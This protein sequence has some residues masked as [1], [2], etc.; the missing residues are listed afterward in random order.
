MKV[1]VVAY[2][3]LADHDRVWIEYVRQAHDP[4]AVR[5]AVHFTLVF[6]SRRLWTI[7]RPR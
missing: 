7:S 1:A 5:I 6:P 3:T 4:Q 2:P